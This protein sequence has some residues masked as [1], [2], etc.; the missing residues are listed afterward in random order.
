[1][2]VDANLHFGQGEERVVLAVENQR[3]GGCPQREKL[4]EVE[5][6]RE[7]CDVWRAQPK[8]GAERR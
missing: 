2:N 3:G 1:M 8:R 6:R 5:Q 4:R 7:T